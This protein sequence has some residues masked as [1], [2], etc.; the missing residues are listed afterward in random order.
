V[1][2]VPYNGHDVPSR[3]DGYEAGKPHLSHAQGRRHPQSRPDFRLI[4]FAIAV[5]LTIQCCAEAM[6][7]WGSRRKDP[8]TAGRVLMAKRYLAPIAL[9]F[10]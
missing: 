7:L 3:D 10:R 6:N 8:V 9:V 4:L 1:R 2:T 5:G